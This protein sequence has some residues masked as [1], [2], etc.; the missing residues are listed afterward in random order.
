VKI[1]ARGTNDYYILSGH[2]TS[3]LNISILLEIFAFHL[4]TLGTIGKYNCSHRK[5]RIFDLNLR[6][7]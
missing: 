1:H 2:K 7:P 4:N 5:K 3:F 6:N